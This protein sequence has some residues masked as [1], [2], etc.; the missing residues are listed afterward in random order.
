MGCQVPRYLAILA[1][2]Q[3]PDTGDVPLDAQKQDAHAQEA[4]PDSDVDTEHLRA[5]RGAPLNEEACDHERTR[6]DREKRCAQ[7]EEA[8]DENYCSHR[9]GRPE[10]RK[11]HAVSTE[12]FPLPVNSACRL[13][14]RRSRLRAAM[15]AEC[16]RPWNPAPDHLQSG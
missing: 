15:F 6:G 5:L 8:E 11:A 1:E 2:R 4:S 12:R 9:P 7:I 14:P 16:A 3:C 10:R 13:H